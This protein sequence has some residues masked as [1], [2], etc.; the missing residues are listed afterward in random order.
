V[1]KILNEIDKMTEKEALSLWEIAALLDPSAARIIECN[2]IKTVDTKGCWYHST[3]FDD[4]GNPIQGFVDQAQERFEWPLV[5]LRLFSSLHGHYKMKIVF[6][7]YEL[8]AESSFLYRVL[9]RLNSD[10]G[11]NQTGEMLSLSFFRNRGQRRLYEQGI[12]HKKGSLFSLVDGCFCVE[13]RAA[14][15]DRFGRMIRPATNQAENSI[16][17]QF[18]EV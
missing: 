3:L 9:V 15:V 6:A 13:C 10:I 8:R 14:F 18:E 7:P 12:T 5:A 16:V 1:S 4:V 2:G 17:K 11:I